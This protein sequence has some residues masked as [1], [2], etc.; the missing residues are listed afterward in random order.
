MNDRTRSRSLTTDDGA[1]DCCN[2]VVEPSNDDRKCNETNASPTISD[3]I[4]TPRASGSS[5][6]RYTL[7]ADSLVDA[8]ELSPLF[9]DEKKFPNVATP[10][11]NSP[12]P[13]QAGSSP[14]VV[15]FDLL[16]LSPMVNTNARGKKAKR[17]TPRRL[18]QAMRL[19]EG[20]NSSPLA[21]KS[22]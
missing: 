7:N 16:T 13:P 22:A 9:E 19:A 21:R 14:A 1:D 5:G 6:S 4:I 17:L 11:K 20:Q 15:P 2:P 12:T 8:V 3:E 10:K 18:R